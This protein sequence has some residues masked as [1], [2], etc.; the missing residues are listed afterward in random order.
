[1]SYGDAEEPARDL[2]R[3]RRLWGNIRASPPSGQRRTSVCSMKSATRIVAL[4]FV[5]TIQLSSLRAHE[6][7]T[8]IL[9]SGESLTLELIG[10]R[11]DVFTVQRNG[12]ELQIPLALVAALN[13]VGGEIPDS[14]WGL[15]ASGRH[16]LVLRNGP[17][18]QGRLTDV[19]GTLPL[20][21]RFEDDSGRR[22]YLSSGVAWIL[23]AP[24]EVPPVPP[25]TRIDLNGIYLAPSSGSTLA[26]AVASATTHPRG[27]RR[28]EGQVYEM[29][30]DVRVSEGTYTPFSD[31]FKQPLAVGLDLR[32]K[33]FHCDV[34]LHD[35]KLWQDDAEFF[36]IGAGRQADPADTNTE[37]FF[38][39]IYRYGRQFALY[40]ETD[41][42]LYRPETTYYAAVDE[43]RFRVRVDVD[44][45]GTEAQLTVWPLNGIGAGAEHKVNPL[46]LDLRN[47]DVR[48][49][50]FFAGFTQ[51]QSRINSKA[52]VTLS[53]CRFS[54]G[55]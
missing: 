11:A 30:L 19:D 2:Q 42:A 45:R 16:L 50:S 15:L 25:G 23:L 54:E 43:T 20:L 1:M 40:M 9:R 10:L 51:N 39:F 21:I 53:N 31:D 32:G 49:A 3:T 4:I 14:R 6:P 35:T 37:E 44:A 41:W 34:E 29:N 52:Q 12:V 55:P 22:D 5:S 47:D 38:V 48:N 27:D 8:L 13:F 46:P 33:S 24:I 28:G 36:Q 18:I 17:G 7:V 26:G